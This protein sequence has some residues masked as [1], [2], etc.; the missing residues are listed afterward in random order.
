ELAARQRRQE[1]RRA[2]ARLA[3]ARRARGRRGLLVPVAPVGGGRREVPL[4]HGPARRRALAPVPRRRRTRRDPARPRA[5]RGQPAEA[6]ARR[7][8][9]RLGLVVDERARLAP[10]RPPALPTGGARL[11]LGVP[12]AR[13]PCRR[14][15]TS[16]GTTS[17]WRPCCTSSPP[18]C[19]TA[20][21]RSSRAAATS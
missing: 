17:S 10:D 18:R 9:L 21:P 19:A 2:R 4:R 20:S 6:R 12:R 15:P 11:V 16:R 5:R 3:H 7:D 14:P 13:R 8:R 1:A